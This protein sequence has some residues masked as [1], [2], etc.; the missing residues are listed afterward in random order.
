VHVCMFN[1][2]CSEQQSVGVYLSLNQ[3]L[4][5]L[6][7]DPEPESLNPRG[8]PLNAPRRPLVSGLCT[9]TLNSKLNSK[10]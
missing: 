10:L 4:R 1:G 7:S 6:N 8:T 3:K 5:T 9:S 2:K